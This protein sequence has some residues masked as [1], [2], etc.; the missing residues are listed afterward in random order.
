MDCARSRAD[1]YVFDFKGCGAGGRA[2]EERELEGD[3]GGGS[4]I[5]C[6]V[7]VGEVC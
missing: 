4:L 7:G 1:L 6:W 5:L 3:R 2:T